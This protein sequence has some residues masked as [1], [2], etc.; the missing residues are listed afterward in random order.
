MQF[1]LDTDG[2]LYLTYNIGAP[3]MGVEL[4]ANDPRKILTDPVVLWDFDPAQEW[5]HFGDNKQHSTQG[6]VEGSQMFKIG[7]TYYLSVAAGG[8]EHTT[9]ATG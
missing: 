8:T 9:Y 5:L 1:F 2:R 4:D 7:S 3:I 6:W